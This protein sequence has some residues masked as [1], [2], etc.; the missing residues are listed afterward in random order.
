MMFSLL[1]ISL[2]C[3]INIT[4]LNFSTLSDCISSLLCIFASFILLILPLLV[5]SSVFTIKE[6]FY[7]IVNVKMKFVT[8]KQLYLQFLTIYFVRRLLIAFIMVFYTS[9]S[10]LMFTVINFLILVYYI[11]LV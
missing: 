2:S 10:N 7:K 9:L 4:Y 8:D 6:K 1:E 5:F 3:F 11:S